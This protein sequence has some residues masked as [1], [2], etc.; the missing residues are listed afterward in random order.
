MAKQKVIPQE[1][2]EALNNQQQMCAEL[3]E[4]KKKLINDLQQVTI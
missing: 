1:L 3:I 4:D 2:Q